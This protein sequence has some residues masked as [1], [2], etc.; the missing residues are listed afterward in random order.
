MDD[1]LLSERVRLK[2][3]KN[4]RALDN[5]DLAQAQRAAAGLPQAKVS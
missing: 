5:F 4:M 1:D 3:A 2:Q